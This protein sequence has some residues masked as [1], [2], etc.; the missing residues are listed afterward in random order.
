[1]DDFARMVHLEH[2]VALQCGIALHGA[3]VE[4]YGLSVGVVDKQSTGRLNAAR[5]LELHALSGIVAGG[6]HGMTRSKPEPESE[7]SDERKPVFHP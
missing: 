2:V 7:H 3:L 5:E 6:A 1:M 4:K